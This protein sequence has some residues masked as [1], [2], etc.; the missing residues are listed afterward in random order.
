MYQHQQNIG[1]LLVL[2]SKYTVLQLYTSGFICH[3]VNC[4]LVAVLVLVL[5]CV[6]NSL[7]VVSFGTAL[8]V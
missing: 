3:Y 1:N 2:T 8:S 6:S 7:T 4:I 5:V